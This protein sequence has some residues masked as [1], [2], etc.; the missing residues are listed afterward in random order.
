MR[1]FVVL[2]LATVASGCAWSSAS[3]RDGTQ[4]S[5]GLVAFTTPAHEYAVVA[6]ANA[7][8]RVASYVAGHRNMVVQAA[9]SAHEAIRAG[10]TPAGEGRAMRAADLAFLMAQCAGDSSHKLKACQAACA[11]NAQAAC[12]ILRRRSP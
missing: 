3:R 8:E 7:V 10:Q 4:S 9:W 6:R 12:Q 11:Q 1:A 2:M 5:A